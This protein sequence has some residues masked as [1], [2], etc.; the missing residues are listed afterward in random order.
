MA[1]MRRVDHATTSEGSPSSGLMEC[2]A[3][4]SGTLELLGSGYGVREPHDHRLELTACDTI[5]NVFQSVILFTG[6]GTCR[7]LHSISVGES[8]GR[9]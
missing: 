8:Y 6:S 3:Y 5:H 4:Y 9:E 1:R 7:T 2:I